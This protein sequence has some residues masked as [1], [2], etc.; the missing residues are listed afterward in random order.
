MVIPILFM[1]LWF[2]NNALYYTDTQAEIF[3]FE[4]HHTYD[5]ELLYALT[6]SC[7]VYSLVQPILN[8]CTP[9]EP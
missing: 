6:Y 5:F 2:N 1:C 7:S 8:Y 4:L 3:Y 9:P